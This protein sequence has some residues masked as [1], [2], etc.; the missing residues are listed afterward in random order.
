[1]GSSVSLAADFAHESLAEPRSPKSFEAHT[2]IQKLLKSHRIHTKDQ[3]VALDAKFMVLKKQNIRGFSL[4]R[5]LH[6]KALEL[7]DDVSN[8]N[9]FAEVVLK[10]H[11]RVKDLMEKAKE[12]ESEKLGQQQIKFLVGLDREKLNSMVAKEVVLS[13]IMKPVD[14]FVAMHFFDRQEV[15]EEPP[16][17]HNRYRLKS[18]AVAKLEVT[19]CFQQDIEVELMTHS[20]MPR[21]E[22]M[23]ANIAGSSFEIS[24]INKVMLTFL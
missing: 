6:R 22:M 23:W 2:V 10:A 12:I 17:R 20:R 4:L 5:E 19:D 14:L 16:K 9:G 8:K 1:M 18:A 21:F 3:L 24:L 13:E 7:R 15:K 11:R